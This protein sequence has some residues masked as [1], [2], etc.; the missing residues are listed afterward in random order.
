MDRTT[1]EMMNC[2]NILI[3][4]IDNLPELAEQFPESE[5]DIDIL[6][7]YVDYEIKKIL[8]D[9]IHNEKL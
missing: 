5:N 8:K 6:M 1:Q 4:F 3:K 2:V 9:I 7:P